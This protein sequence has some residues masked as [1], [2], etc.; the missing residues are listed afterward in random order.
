[1]LELGVD[2]SQVQGSCCDFMVRD[3]LE[4]LKSKGRE[5]KGGTYDAVLVARQEAARE[6]RQVFGCAGLFGGLVGE[7]TGDFGG[8]GWH[9]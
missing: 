5:E 9:G 4:Y 2:G 8:F 7:R 6:A 1:M 3:A